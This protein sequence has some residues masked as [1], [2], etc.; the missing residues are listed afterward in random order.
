[1]AACLLGGCVGPT[2]GTMPPEREAMVEP[3]RP[4]PAGPD[5]GTGAGG[6]AAPQRRAVSEAKPAPKPKPLPP[7]RHDRDDKASLMLVPVPHPAPGLDPRTLVGLDEEKLR[8]VLGEPNEV[9]EKSPSRVWSY[10]VDG[11]SLT[12]FLYMDLST[13]TFRALTYNVKVVGHPVA[14]RTVEVCVKRIQSLNR[15]QPKKS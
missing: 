12:L 13:K 6:A 11:C 5:A 15:G 7:R 10:S 8:R 9:K 3:E 14:T 4:A 1:M 2:D